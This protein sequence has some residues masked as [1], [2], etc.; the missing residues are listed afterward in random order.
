MDHTSP[1]PSLDYSPT[2]STASTEITVDPLFSPLLPEIHN[3]VPKQ[4]TAQSV[5]IGIAEAITH[6]CAHQGGLANPSIVQETTSCAISFLTDDP[7]LQQAY[8]R[9][10]MYQLKLI[11]QQ[12]LGSC[13]QM[14]LPTPNTT[15][16]NEFAPQSAPPVAPTA[17]ATSSTRASEKTV[18]DYCRAPLSRKDALKRHLEKSCTFTKEANTSQHILYIGRKH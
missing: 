18:C 12:Q 2:I 13:I 11:M 3:A 4:Y 1:L 14:Q 5:A 16:D 15:N 6:N 7:C 10:I 8:Y 17:R 9:D